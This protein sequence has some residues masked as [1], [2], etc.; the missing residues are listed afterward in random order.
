MFQY[1]PINYSKLNYL[2][3]CIIIVDLQ[4]PRAGQ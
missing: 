1:I 4:A 3:D 2:C